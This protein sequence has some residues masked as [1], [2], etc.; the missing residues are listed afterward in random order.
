MSG[1]ARWSSPVLRDF[2]DAAGQFIGRVELEER[3]GPELA[4]GKRGI[5]FSLI[6]GSAMLMKLLM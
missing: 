1:I 5:D 4:F 3:V 2:C 6:A